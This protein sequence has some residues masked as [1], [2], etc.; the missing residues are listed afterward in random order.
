M[1]TRAPAAAQ[2]YGYTRCS[3]LNETYLHFVYH[4]NRDDSVADEFYLR[5]W[6]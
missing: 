2:V 3:V 5:R 1:L 6:E 4:H